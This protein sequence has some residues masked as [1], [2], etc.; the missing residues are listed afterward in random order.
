[1]TLTQRFALALRVTLSYVY[2]L[3]S[4]LLALSNP[5]PDVPSSDLLL[6]F[7]RLR[8]GGFHYVL[9]TLCSS[10]CFSLFLRALNRRKA[11]NMVDGSS[12]DPCLCFILDPSVRWA[13]QITS[14][15]R[16]ARRRA[17][18]HL[19]L[20]LDRIETGQA[21]FKLTH[22]RRRD[23]V[24]EFLGFG[25]RAEFDFISDLEGVR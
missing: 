10:R 23:V 6:F 22:Y 24:D 1:M 9:A 3:I 4:S 12:S 13:G 5:S 8:G 2:G 18:W 15:S 17:R 21:D 16:C 20:L 7:C 25:A 14:N 19:F 11:R